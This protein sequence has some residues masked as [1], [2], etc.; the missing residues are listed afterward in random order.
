MKQ[1]TKTR[2]MIIGIFLAVAFT[3]GFLLHVSKQF[4]R[5]GDIKQRSYALASTYVAVETYID[6]HDGRWPSSW[7]DLDGL[8]N[9][10]RPQD[11]AFD[12]A[13]SRSWVAVDFK[14]KPAELLQSTPESFKA[15]KP[16]G[17]VMAGFVDPAYERLIQTLERHHAERSPADADDL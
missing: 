6:R 14:A 4:E 13:F 16:Y 12:A 7:D 3:L 8:K 15:I 11:P 10:Q 9:P 1:T 17:E 5:V 2:L